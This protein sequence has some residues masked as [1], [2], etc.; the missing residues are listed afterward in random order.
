MPSADLSFETNPQAVKITSALLSYAG[1]DVYHTQSP[2]PTVVEYFTLA[3]QHNMLIKTT[4]MPVKRKSNFVS[5]R[6][7]NDA[8]FLAV[9]K[10]YDSGRKKENGVEEIQFTHLHNICLGP[11]SFHMDSKR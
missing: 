2:F 8:T 11:G 6:P 1:Q 3:K 9:N 4:I 10:T 7:Y 5:D